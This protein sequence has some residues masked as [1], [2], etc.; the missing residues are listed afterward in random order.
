M[1]EPGFTVVIPTFNRPAPLRECL[2]AVGRLRAPAGG[3]EVV[4]VNDG[5]IDPSDHVRGAAGG[6]A[7]RFMEQAN[8]GPGAARNLGARAARGRWLAF[9][10]DDCLP[11]RDWLL[12]LESALADAPDALVGGSVVNALASNA[13][14]EASQRLVTWVTT[15]FDG[16]CR[17]RFFTSN[18]IAVAREAFLGIGGFDE[19]FGVGAGEDREFCDRWHA[20]ARPSAR[21]PDAVIRHAH[22][23][24]LR[25]FLRQH[26][27]YGAGARAFRNA[28][29]SAGRATRVDLP[30]YLGSVRNAMEGRGL[31]GGLVLA[32]LT[33]AAHAAYLAGLAGSTMHQALSSRGAGK[34]PS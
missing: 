3:F 5:G 32:G 11:T 13:Y 10:D 6:V 29:A 15:Y 30:F 22:A 31:A 16:T 17:E 1:R 25:A 12:H 24:D 26:H 20:E 14:A 9:T 21:A 4:V 23:L 34:P 19:T 7:V 28:R 2:R 18:N 27:G 8:R 33:L